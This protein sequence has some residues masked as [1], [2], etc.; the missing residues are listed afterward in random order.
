MAAQHLSLSGSN[1]NCKQNGDDR[2]EKREQLHDSVVWLRLLA[3]RVD[4]SGRRFELKGPAKLCG[5]VLLDVIRTGASRVLP[6]K[7]RASSTNCL[8]KPVQQ[9]IRI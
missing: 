5:C 1:R 7:S 4:Y 9:Q 6:K 3:N 2:P 8:L